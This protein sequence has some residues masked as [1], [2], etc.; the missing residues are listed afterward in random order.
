[1]TCLNCGFQNREAAGFCASCG[2]AL[3]SK[4]VASTKAERRYAEGKNPFIATVVSFLFP[5]GGQLY[6][7]DF[8]KMGAIWFAYIVCLVLA[9]TM[10]GTP[11]AILISLP[12][13]GFAI[14][15]AYGV[16]KREKAIW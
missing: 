15:D 14:V 2:N 6:N 4:S 10:I 3:Q 16:A 13:W 12:V 7:G 9:L 11:L 5:A 1:M 8:K